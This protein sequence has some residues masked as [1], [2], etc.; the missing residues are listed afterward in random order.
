MELMSGLIVHWLKKYSLF[1]MLKKCYY[2]G[3]KGLEYLRKFFAPF[4]SSLIIL[5]HVWLVWVQLMREKRSMCM[6]SLP[7]PVMVLFV[8]MSKAADIW[9]V[10]GSYLLASYKI[11]VVTSIR[12][13]RL[14]FDVL[15]SAA[16]L[17]TKAR[18]WNW[19]A[20]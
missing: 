7:N 19:L 8:M 2:L 12:H 10:R 11:W 17:C 18:I 20:F 6:P 3:L 4:L 5:Q 16:L 14:L 15:M 1:N 13:C 9:K